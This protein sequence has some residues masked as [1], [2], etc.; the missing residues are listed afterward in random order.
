MGVYADFSTLRYGG[1]FP[2]SYCKGTNRMDV[3]SVPYFFKSQSLGIKLLI[4]RYRHSFITL[5][6][7][8]SYMVEF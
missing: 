2:W 4:K 8:D 1:G 3:Y 6:F 7:L 5:D